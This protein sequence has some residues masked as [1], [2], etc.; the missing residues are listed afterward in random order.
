MRAKLINLLILF[1][2][3]LWLNSALAAQ[4]S[5]VVYPAWFKESLYD[6]QGDLQDARAA[7]KKGIMVFYSMETCSYC[8]AI[9][10]KAFKEKEIAQRLNQNYDVI[11]LDVFSDNELVDPRGKTH[12]TKEFAVV[13][14]AKFT[15]TMIFYGEG[16]AI[17]LRL[18]GYQSPEK[19]RAV[20]NYLE[21]DNYTRMSL[22]QFMKQ[23]QSATKSAKDKTVNQDLDRRKSSDRHLMVVFESDDCSKCQLLREMLKAEVLQPY[24]L[25][26]DVA[27]VSSSDT[28]NRI[29]TPEGKQ[30]SGK[31]WADQ[32]GLIHNPAM[33]FF[34]GEGKEVLRVDTDILLNKDGNDI[35]ADDEKVLDNIRARLQFVV[36]KGY[37]ALPQFQ[38]WRAQQKRKARE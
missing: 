2:V 17:Q 32:L 35:K 11:G 7:G 6:L 30:L 13:E 28:Q 12:W 26:L 25:R 38:R 16:G 22:R 1:T 33:V 21:G 14:K 36:D 15:P 29:T 23:G 27:F 3:L 18:V 8:L 37:V 20:L 4:G 31:A 10:E 24:L 9:L 19:M 34:Y 5:R